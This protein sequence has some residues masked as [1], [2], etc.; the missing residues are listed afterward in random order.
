MCFMINV[1]YNTIFCLGISNIIVILSLYALFRMFYRRVPCFSVNECTD[2]MLELSFLR[3]HHTPA[4][5]Q[6]TQQNQTKLAHLLI[7]HISI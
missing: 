2:E 7:L 3:P 6:C 5:L 4:W 1:I